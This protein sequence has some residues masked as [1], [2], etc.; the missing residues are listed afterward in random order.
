MRQVTLFFLASLVA[1]Q[2]MPV[3]DESS[4][5]YLPPSGSLL[6]LNQDISVPP[7]QAGVY[8]QYGKIVPEK[9]INSYEANCKFEVRNVA[10]NYRKVSPD[11]FVITKAQRETE[12]V[13]SQPIQY[14][15]VRIGIGMGVGMDG[16]PMAEIY[17]TTYYLHSTKQPQ[18]LYLTCQHWDEPTFGHYLKLD[19]IRQ[20][21]GDIM[22]IR[23]AGNN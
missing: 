16:G 22:T 2:Q 10:S 19:Q 20:A 8:L 1:C 21:L 15:S 6:V 7:N 3:T 4:P 9:L 17:T 5:N 23:I 11:E 12:V 13:L 18:V 14:A